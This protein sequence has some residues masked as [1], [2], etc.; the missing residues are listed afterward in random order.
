MK[1]K[2]VAA[3]KAK[4]APRKAAAAAR[5]TDAT[6]TPWLDHIEFNFVPYF[7]ALTVVLLG[8]QL[9]VRRDGVV[10]SRT[11]ASFTE[12][13]G[14]A[15]LRAGDSAERERPYREPMLREPSRE[16]DQPASWVPSRK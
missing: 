3:A 6:G 10:D 1:K 16:T 13:P 12:R 14:V 15:Q 4:K 5:V 7:V 11:P 2:S 9:I 8:L